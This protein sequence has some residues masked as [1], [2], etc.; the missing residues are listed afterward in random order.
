MVGGEKMEELRVGVVGYS[1]KKFDKVKAMGDIKEAY[2]KIE[3]KFPGREIEIVSVLIDLGIPALAYREA[4]K[5]G[6]RTV[7]IACSLAKDYDCFPVDD[8]IIIGEEWGD[9][10]AKFLDSIDALI[11][12]GGG[13]QAI[14]ETNETKRRNKYVIEYDLSALE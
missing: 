1:A 12:I 9:E 6:W 2:D 4:L 11:R 5:R 13:G 3:K 14:N 7:G 8:K 10:S